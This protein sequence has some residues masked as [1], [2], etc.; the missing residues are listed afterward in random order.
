MNRCGVFALDDGGTTYWVSVVNAT[1]LGG[2]WAWV[3]TNASD[4]YCSYTL[5]DGANWN[6]F[7]SESLSL[8]LTE[9]PAPSSLALL[10]L[11]GLIAGRRRR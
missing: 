5:D 3:T 4:Y 8:R 7:A 11:G 6:A 1:G 9:V 10:S 2:D